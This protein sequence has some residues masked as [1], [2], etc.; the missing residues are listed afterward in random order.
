MM[1]VCIKLFQ[2]LP[3][4]IRRIIYGAIGAG[5]ILF[6]G[7]LWTSGIILAWSAAFGNPGLIRFWHS[8]SFQDID[9]F[10]T[11]PNSSML[12]SWPD[13]YTLVDVAAEFNRPDIIETLHDLGAGIT[14]TGAARSP[15]H[16]AA[17][18]GSCLLYTSDAADE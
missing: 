6:I 16:V 3:G 8:I 9:D 11:L 1:E 4:T 12:I 13:S 17:K 5:P 7:Y 2:K 15:F 18:R 10:V 14:K